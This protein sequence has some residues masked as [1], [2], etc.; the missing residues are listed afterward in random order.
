MP[1]AKKAEVTSALP[2]P[3]QVA[4]YNQFVAG[5]QPQRIELTDVSA[6][7]MPTELEHITVKVESKF[8]LSC[9]SRR[10]DSFTIEARLELWFRS[11]DGV[12]VGHLNGTYRLEYHSTVVPT[13]E[14]VELFKQ[15]NAPMAVWPFMRE[16]VLNLT[17]RFGWSGFVLPTFLIPPVSPP[18]MA[19]SDALPL[20]SEQPSKPSRKAA[21]R[22]RS[23]SK[24]G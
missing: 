10:D 9:L 11:E 6:R 15:R 5:V 18:E 19:A 23:T 24:Q 17:Q 7:T 1:R 13:A 8:V 20:V 4:L 14:L 22:K 3:D 16:L 2:E 21:T 12:E